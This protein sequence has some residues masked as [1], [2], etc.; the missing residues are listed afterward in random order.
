MKYEKIIASAYNIN[1]AIIVGKRHNN[2]IDS[3]IDAWIMKVVTLDTPSGFYTDQFR[4]IDRKEAL[5][6]AKQN[7]QFKGEQCWDILYSENLR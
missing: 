7:W 4:Y 1:W 3:I 2:C 6:L 5:L